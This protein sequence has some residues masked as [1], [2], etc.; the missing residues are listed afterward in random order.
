MKLLALG[1]YG[2]A[3]NRARS[4]FQRAAQNMPRQPL[5]ATHY[6]LERM[7]KE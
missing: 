1:S 5:K 4:N 3:A 6:L 2:I 7:W